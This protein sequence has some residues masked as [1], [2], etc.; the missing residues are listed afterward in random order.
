M[1]TKQILSGG[2]QSLV[3]SRL[4]G[5]S[6]GQDF[7]ISPWKMAHPCKPLKLSAKFCLIRKDNQYGFAGQEQDTAMISL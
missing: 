3:F 1:P 5:F 6:M 4:T 7:Y 2:N